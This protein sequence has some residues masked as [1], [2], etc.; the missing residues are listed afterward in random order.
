[1]TGEQLK[2]KK[3]Q[4][5]FGKEKIIRKEI[6]SIAVPAKGYKIFLSE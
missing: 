2:F 4:N 1:L 3:Y 6:S 5:I